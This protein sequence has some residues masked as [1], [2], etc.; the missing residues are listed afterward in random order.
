[1][2]WSETKQV[3]CNYWRGRGTL[4]WGF[5]VWTTDLSCHFVMLQRPP[6]ATR[7][8]PPYS[9][10]CT[11]STRTFLSTE[12]TW[13][14][15]SKLLGRSLLCQQEPVVHAG[16]ATCRKPW[17]TSW[18]G[19]RR[20]SST[21]SRSSLQMHRESGVIS[22]PRPRTSASWPPP[23]PSWSTPAFSTTSRTSQTP[24]S[25]TR[26]A[27]QRSTTHW[28]WPSLHWRRSK[29]CRPLDLGYTKWRRAVSRMSNWKG[30]T[31]HSHHQASCSLIRSSPA[32]TTVLRT[33]GKGCWKPRRSSHSRLGPTKPTWKTLANMKSGS[34]QSTSTKFWRNRRWMQ[35]NCL[36]NG[37]RSVTP[38]QA[39]RVGGAP[40]IRHLEGN[41]PA[42]WWDM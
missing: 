6:T 40:K 13:I 11:C 15:V 30:R 19:T 33:W 35:A 37:S 39:G 28:R 12:L 22:R 5:I 26:S 4:L 27:F 14:T 21:F 32:W 24:C 29:K 20:L 42:A 23:C 9:W 1:M 10:G 18:R 31:A 8:C 38:V 36:L 7:N 16:W 2:L 17:T 41:E 34:S 3:W 25:L